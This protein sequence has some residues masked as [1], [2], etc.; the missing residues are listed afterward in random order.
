LFEEALKNGL[1]HLL[2][3]GCPGT[4]TISTGTISLFVLTI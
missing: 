4:G 1:V 3:I 2:C